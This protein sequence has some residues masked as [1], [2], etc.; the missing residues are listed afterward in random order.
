MFIGIGSCLNVP[1]S[2]L[3]REGFRPLLRKLAIY[4]RNVGLSVFDLLVGVPSD[5]IVLFG[6]KAAIKILPCLF[7]KS[8]GSMDLV[9]LFLPYLA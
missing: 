6:L 9:S 8:L 3:G 7:G 2:I 1:E 4:A 5:S